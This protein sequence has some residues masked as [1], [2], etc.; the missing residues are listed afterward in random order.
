[1]RIAIA[2]KGLNGLDDSISD[3]FG[4]S[5]TF[6]IINIK[7]DTIRSVHPESNKSTSVEHSAGPLTCA[8]LIKLGVNVVVAAEFGPTVSSM[9]SESKIK[10][11]KVKAGIKVKD[12]LQSYLKIAQQ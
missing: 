1:M 6:T 7:N 8:R 3:V 4:R 9:L 2:T 12:I 10:E 5:P 11:V